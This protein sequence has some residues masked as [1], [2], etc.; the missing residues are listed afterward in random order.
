MVSSSYILTPTHSLSFILTSYPPL[1][2][3]Y[4]IARLKVE[5]KYLLPSF[6]L[7]TPLEYLI[8]T[9]V[10]AGACTT[11]LTDFLVLTHNNFIEACQGFIKQYQRWGQL[12]LF[13]SHYQCYTFSSSYRKSQWREYKL[14]ITHIHD[15]HL[16]I[17]EQQL[18]SIIL[19]H[20]HYSLVVGKGQDVCYDLPALEKHLLDHFIHG[21][22][23]ILSDIPQVVYQKDI[24]TAA[25]FASVR[26]KVE[27]QV[28][29]QKNT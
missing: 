15:C 11:P 29:I 23:V 22:P 27:P 28:S 14:P 25:T 26:K 8:P 24:Y 6:T 9:T 12:R 3:A 18:P 1:A 2:H 7:D 10:G 5:E 4:N 13:N 21:K 19:S 16:L 17:Y 20:C